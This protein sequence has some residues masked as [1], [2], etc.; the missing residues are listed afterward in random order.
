MSK[1]ILLF[2]VQNRTETGEEPTHRPSAEP[3]PTRPVQYVKKEGKIQK[4]TRKKKEK[5][6]PLNTEQNV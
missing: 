5:K 6:N 4:Y 1:I 3:E 2:P